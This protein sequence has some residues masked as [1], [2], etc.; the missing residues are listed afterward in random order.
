MEVEKFDFGS[1]FQKVS[2]MM[3]WIPCS[4]TGKAENDVGRAWPRRNEKM[5]GTGQSWRCDQSLKDK[6]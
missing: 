5:K 3:S 1:W 4:G 2:S 6:S